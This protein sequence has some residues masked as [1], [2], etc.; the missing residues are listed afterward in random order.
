M[1]MPPRHRWAPPGRLLLLTILF[2][3]HFVIPSAAVWPFS[4]LFG[5]SKD[6]DVDSSELTEWQAEELQELQDEVSLLP[7]SAEAEAKYVSK[8]LT[9]IDV[10][11]AEAKLTPDGRKVYPSCG[12]VRRAAEGGRAIAI[13]FCTEKDVLGM[14]LTKMQ[15]CV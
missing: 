5:R 15:C 14:H 9:P 10:Q 11:A 6:D 2:F 12:M 7:V 3:S 13:T 4:S 1:T 8:Q